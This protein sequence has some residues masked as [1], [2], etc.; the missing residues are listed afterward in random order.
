MEIVSSIFY[1]I[2]FLGVG[3]FMCAIPF[4]F[5]TSLFKKDKEDAEPW[6]YIL[7]GII[8]LAVFFIGFG[9]NIQWHKIF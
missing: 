7:S 6:M 8:T 9:D 4:I 5:I 2:L 3:A 1:G